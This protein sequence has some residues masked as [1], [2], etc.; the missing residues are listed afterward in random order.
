MTNAA[1]KAAGPVVEKFASSSGRWFGISAV[2]FCAVV[3]AVIV[4]DDPAKGLDAYA[5]LAAACLVVWVVLIRPGASIRANGVLLQNM[6]RDS[7]I[8]SAKIERCAVFQT[9]QV[10]TADRHFHCV[11][12]SKSAR[13]QMK[14]KTGL[15]F[16]SAL[17]GGF[18]KGS[19]VEK[20]PRR[21]GEV[22]I[23]G[24]YNDYVA[25]RIL[26]LRDD[27]VDDGTEPVVAVEPT[28]IAALLLAAVLVVAAFL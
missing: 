5:I 3:T 26:R 24:H 16:G 13:T 4:L 21:Q 25:T 10:A 14:E 17:L 15:P 27:A 28:S 9:L 18:N 12:L 2:L 1:V 11:G 19:E 23:G 8:P 7:F 20:G 6:V 22:V